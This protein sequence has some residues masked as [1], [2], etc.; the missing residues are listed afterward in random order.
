[1]HTKAAFMRVGI[2]GGFWTSIHLDGFMPYVS[3]HVR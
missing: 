2:D 1:L 3:S